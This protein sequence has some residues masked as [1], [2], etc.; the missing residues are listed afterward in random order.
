[1]T[2][3]EILPSLQAAILSVE[4]VASEASAANS[5]RIIES[6]FQF[7]R[8]IGLAF[9]LVDDALDFSA[10]AAQMGKPTGADLQLGLATGPV[11]FAAQEVRGRAHDA[12]NS[13]WASCISFPVCVGFSAIPKCTVQKKALD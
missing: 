11:L 7:G 12:K 2:I 5:Q 8:H 9:Q 6:A 13:A 4:A 10:S 1:M 3:Q